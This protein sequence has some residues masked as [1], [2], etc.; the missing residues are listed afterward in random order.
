MTELSAVSSSGSSPVGSSSPSS[1]VR[2][3]LMRLR[4]ISNSA[5]ICFRLFGER[6]NPRWLSTEATRRSKTA[7]CFEGIRS[8]QRRARANG[9]TSTKERKS[10]AKRT[11]RSRPSSA[12]RRIFPM[13]TRKGAR[14]S[15]QSRIS[16]R[17]LSLLVQSA[18][19][20]DSIVW[21]L[22]EN[23]SSASA[24]A[25]L[26]MGSWPSSLPF[27]SKNSIRSCSSGVVAMPM[28][29][30]CFP[31][32]RDSSPSR[33]KMRLMALTS[34]RTVRSE[35]ARPSAKEAAGSQWSMDSS[36]L[37]MIF[38]RA[39]TFGA[40]CG[41]AEKRHLTL[42]RSRAKGADILAAIP[43]RKLGRPRRARQ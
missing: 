23:A 30:P 8:P 31:S 4:P 5:R 19:A 34:R 21:K 22:G 36:F 26:S 29:L 40:S 42:S 16:E 35:Q 25:R 3:A 41:S 10:T 37:R 38:C 24:R 27:D 2:P 1:S 7:W 18:R 28:P 11:S 32:M 20:R 6:R 12:R 15:S 43:A 9:G 39:F 17:S 13:W 14:D 33:S